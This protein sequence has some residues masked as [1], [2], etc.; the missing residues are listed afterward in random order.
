MTVDIRPQK[1]SQEDFLVSDAD[2]TI[3][4]GAAGSGKSHALLMDCLQHID[5]PN[6]Y[7]VYF[8][9]NNTQLDGL[10]K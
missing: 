4:G 9:A 5:D 7:A 8:R 2:I 3:Y 6:Y 1:G 10:T